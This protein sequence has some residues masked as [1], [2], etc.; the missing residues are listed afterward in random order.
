ML[1]HITG[2]LHLQIFQCSAGPVTYQCFTANIAPQLTVASKSFPDV[3]SG[4]GYG[5]IK[6]FI[7]LVLAM[8]KS[9]L[10]PCVLTSI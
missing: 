5:P 10:S 3:N 6:P 1:S 2:G 9:D 8:L 4:V 7:A